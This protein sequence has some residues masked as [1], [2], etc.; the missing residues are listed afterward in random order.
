[1]E[2]LSTPSGSLLDALDD[3]DTDY[4]TEISQC[5]VCNVDD[6]EQTDGNDIVPTESLSDYDVDAIQE[7]LES[8]LSQGK[9]PAEKLLLEKDGYTPQESVCIENLS[10]SSQRTK[11]DSADNE[12]VDTIAGSESPSAIEINS[13]IESSIDKD[14]NVSNNAS[15]ECEEISNKREQ[16]IDV[17]VHRNTGPLGKNKNVSHK[18]LS[19][20]IT[21]E[22]VKSTVSVISV[23]DTDSEDEKMTIKS[24]N[25]DLDN[26]MPCDPV[27]LEMFRIF[28]E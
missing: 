19:G 3:L 23:S 6:I 9:Q 24:N 22:C 25:R 8:S 26:D 21:S 17:V 13:S 7:E 11:T 5:R 2:S 4:P 10:P 14:A 1:L 18:T 27:E 16:R 28:Y 15:L 12:H 20:E